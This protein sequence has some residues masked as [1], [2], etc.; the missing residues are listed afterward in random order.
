[1]HTIKYKKDAHVLLIDTSYYIFHR[2]FGTLKWWEYQKKGSE[3]S[4]LHL[5]EE[6]VNAFERHIIGD[7][8]KLQKRWKVPNENILFCLDSMRHTI[9]RYEHYSDY[10]FGR[11]V[12][13]KFNSEFFPLFYK[14]LS[15]NKFTVLNIEKLEADDVVY[16]ST[17]KIES[18]III[19]TNDNDYLQIDNE[20]IEIHNLSN[21]KTSN[22]RLRSLGNPRKDLLLKILRGDSSD[23]ILPV[24]PKLG[25]KTAEKLIELSDE[26]LH[27]HLVKKNAIDNFNKNKLLISFESIPKEYMEHFNRKY[28]FTTNV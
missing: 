14:F 5:D 2:Y 22:I 28:I 3:Y 17:L 9:W 6:F 24:Y 18:P 21:P 26:E 27:E 25:I 23:N 7:M 16:L 12:S 1:M 11:T 4:N 13:T 15:A 8:K 10:K 20:N 19:I